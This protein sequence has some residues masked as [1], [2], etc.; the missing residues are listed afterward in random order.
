MSESNTSI[1]TITINGV[2]YVRADTLAAHNPEPSG[3]RV[4]VVADRGFIYAGNMTRQEDGNIVLR[5]AV[6]VRRWTKGG[7]GGLLSDP[8]A[9]EATL[10]PVAYPIEFPAGTVLQIVRVP[11]TWGRA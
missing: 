5:N 8:K 6:N 7:M 4:V 11:E 1:E 9:A 2:Q 10:D 3:D